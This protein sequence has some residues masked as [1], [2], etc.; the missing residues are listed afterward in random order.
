VIELGRACCA[1]ACR[2]LPNTS[3]LAR[4]LWVVG[5]LARNDFIVQVASLLRTLVLLLAKW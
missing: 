3:T 1:G 2:Y 5:F 4:F